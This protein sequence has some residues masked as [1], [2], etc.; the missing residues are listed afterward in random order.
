MTR[1]LELRS[2]QPIRF[3]C[4]AELKDKGQSGAITL[5]STHALY[6]FP[7]KVDYAADTLMGLLRPLSATAPS[8]PS[9][10]LAVIQLQHDSSGDPRGRRRCVLLSSL[11]FH[12]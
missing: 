10:P 6:Q 1:H 11:T 3:I 5:L 7:Y 2:R 8:S 12:Y 9:G 4:V